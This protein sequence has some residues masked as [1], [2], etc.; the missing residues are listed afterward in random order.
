MENWEHPSLDK[1]PQVAEDLPRQGMPLRAPPW[2]CSAANPG[3]NDFS[4]AF[5]EN[6]SATPLVQPGA[7]KAGSQPPPQPSVFPVRPVN[8]EPQGMERLRLPGTA[9]L[10]ML[11]VP[12]PI[13]CSD[14]QLPG[15][16][17]SAQPCLLHNCRSPASAEPVSKR[18]R[19]E[20]WKKGVFLLC[21]F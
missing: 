11:F 19:G 6:R 5:G 7:A 9:D 10:R 20:A 21:D 15:H 8:Q 1:K 12:I 2:A 18:R 3:I 17:A 13:A 14:P 16:P 4:L